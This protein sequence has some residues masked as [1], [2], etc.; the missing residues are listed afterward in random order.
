MQQVST[1]AVEM[2]AAPGDDEAYPSVFGA[3]WLADRAA[4]AEKMASL[5]SSLAGLSSELLDV[6]AGAAATNTVLREQR[7]GCAA[8]TDAN[9]SVRQEIIS[10]RRGQLEDLPARAWGGLQ[11]LH[12]GFVAQQAALLDAATDETFRSFPNEF[13]AR[14]KATSGF[15]SGVARLARV[16]GDPAAFRG[17]SARAKLNRQYKDEVMEEAFIQEN[18]DGVKLAA[19]RVAAAAAVKL[20]E[21]ER[22]KTLFGLA[23]VKLAE[24]ARR[25]AERVAVKLAEEDERR[26][27]A[28]AVKAVVASTSARTAARS[29]SVSDLRVAAAARLT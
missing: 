12:V 5:R 13:R 14:N 28:A 23:A 24:D 22:R 20:A 6:Q 1:P 21:D 4:H 2:G 18:A 29:I 7:A 17:V 16:S 9:I 15:M 25:K 19:E 11:Q 10:L 26:S 8:L 27:A 3:E